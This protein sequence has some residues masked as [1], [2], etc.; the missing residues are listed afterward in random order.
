MG[1]G[2]SNIGK[3]GGDFASP[4]ADSVQEIGRSLRNGTYSLFTM[5]KMGCNPF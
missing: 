5:K 2:P 4:S 1:L 3:T